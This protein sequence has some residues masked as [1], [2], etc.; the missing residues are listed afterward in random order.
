MSDYTIVGIVVNPKIKKPLLVGWDGGEIDVWSLDRGG[1]RIGQGSYED[2][3]DEYLKPSYVTGLPRVHTPSGVLVKGK[4]YGTS[5]YTG[6]CVGAHANHE[7]DL[8]VNRDYDG[9]GIC[10]DRENRSASADKWWNMAV[11]LRLA[12]EIEDEHIEEGV[13]LDTYDLECT[14]RGDENV[15]IDYATGD[16]STSIQ[17]NAYYWEAASE[18]DLVVA[19]F[20]GITM[21]G[22]SLIETIA[23]GAGQI[24]LQTRRESYGDRRVLYSMTAGGYRNIWKKLVEHDDAE[25]V[26]RDALFALDMRG[27]EPQ[28]VNV[29]STIAVIDGAADEDIDQMR[30]R[31]ERNLDPETPV[32][33]LRLQF[34]E[35]PSD[36]GMVKAALADTKQLRSSLDWKRLSA[37]P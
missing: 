33:Q 37:L 2:Y 29:L 31:A 4:G 11:R 18:A 3:N 28:A 19:T 1:V 13:E 16:V 7:G 23:S 27:M 6:L 26:N 32:K 15:S 17:A 35:N 24:G 9:D 12:Q 5:L 25:Y 21:R 14:Y 34:K 20:A 22:D 36:E 10:S 8:D 30:L